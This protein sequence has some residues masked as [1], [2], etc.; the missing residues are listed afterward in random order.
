MSIQAVLLPVLVQVALTF[1]LMLG[2]ARLRVG[3]IRRGDVKIKDIALRQPGWPVQTTQVA[4]AY[5]NQLELPLLFYVLTILAYLTKLTDL[6]FVVMAWLFVVSRLAH[7]YVFVTSN[8]VP[9][10]FRTFAAGVFILIAMWLIFA[11]RVLLAI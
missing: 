4:N 8:N 2:M 7:A 5:H 6:L 10:R 1:A 3:S 11:A 9:Q